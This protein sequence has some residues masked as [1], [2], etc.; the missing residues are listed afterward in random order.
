MFDPLG[1]MSEEKKKTPRIMFAD[2]SEVWPR[3]RAYRAPW[4]F[5]CR[6]LVFFFGVSC[7]KKK[8]HKESDNLSSA[9]LGKYPAVINPRIPSPLF[10]SPAQ[11][12]T[13]RPH[14]RRRCLKLGNN[15]ATGQWK[16]AKR[17]DPRTNPWDGNART[18][19][20]ANENPPRPRERNNAPGKRMTAGTTAAV[21]TRSWNADIGKTTPDMNNEKQ[22]TDGEAGS[23]MKNVEEDKMGAIQDKKFG[24]K[25][26]SRGREG[27]GGGLL[28]VVTIW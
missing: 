17:T 2:M 1:Q 28:C 24:W 11:L 27:G 16:S 9:A 7:E 3:A 10:P 6:S 13:T 14:K 21:T 20:Y 19:V 5:S 18:P 25:K 8:I 4:S 15:V 12:G 23:R 22:M 26:K